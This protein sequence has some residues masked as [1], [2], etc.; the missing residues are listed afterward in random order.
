[1]TTKLTVQFLGDFA[2][3][4]L[5]AIF[6]DSGYDLEACRSIYE[7]QFKPFMD[8]YCVGPHE[9]SLHP[10][11][12]FLEMM[13][14]RGCGRWRF[15]NQGANPGPYVTRGESDPGYDAVRVRSTSRAI[16]SCLSATSADAKQ[17]LSTTRS[18]GRAR[19]TRL[20]WL[21]ARRAKSR[22]RRSKRSVWTMR[23]IVR[24]GGKGDCDGL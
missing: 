12:V 5:G 1:M 20:R 19:R 21:C 15:H 22:W 24:R 16:C 6:E 11:S 10:K 18:M 4:V 13:S 17:C 14:G 9:H 8:L 2:E 3:A 7:R 23:V